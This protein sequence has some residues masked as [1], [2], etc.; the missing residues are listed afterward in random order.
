M[1]KYNKGILVLSVF[2]SALFTVNAQ[3][4]AKLFK[5]NCAACHKIDK[6]SIGPKLE[7]AK[8][9]WEEAG[10]AEMLYEWIANPN[11]LYESGKSKMAAAVWDFSPAAMSPMAHLSKEDVDAIFD[12]VDN[13]PPPVTVEE[14]KGGENVAADSTPAPTPMSNGTLVFLLSII[15]FLVI[16]LLVLVNGVKALKNQG[17]ENQIEYEE[18]GFGFLTKS[19][20][21]ENEDAILLDHDYDGI[22]ELDNVLPPWWVW[23]FYGTIIFSVIYWGMYQTFKVWPLQE[24][25][26]VM[27]M[28][29]SEKDVYEYKKANNLLI[30]AETVTFLTEEAEIAAGKELYDGTCKVCHMA[31][32]E[33]SVGPNLT[34]KYWLYGGTAGDIFTS[35]SDGRPNGM[36]E[37][38]S[39]FN[40]KQIQQL[41][42]FIHSLDFKEGKAP[43]G[44]LMK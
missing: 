7:G 44:D 32:G 14:P 30:S 31:D 28:A 27:E 13:P 42:S 9:K 33:G 21:I 37:H 23:M 1:K 43:E 26:Y 22:K 41:A 38:K 16:A 12:Y 10:E 20:A 19:V 29:Q 3:D 24:E 36:P 18:E 5:Q 15:G 8:A 4:G 39:K 2:L 11:D 34:D 17:G 40:E 35:I 25:A 6:K